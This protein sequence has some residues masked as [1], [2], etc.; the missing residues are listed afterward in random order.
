MDSRKQ[1]G[2]REPVPMIPFFH[3]KS[4][5]TTMPRV[6]MAR[7][8]RYW[9]AQTIRKCSQNVFTQ[10]GSRREVARS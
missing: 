2:I 8:R 6:T 3:L 4:V 9:M 7:S 5:G 1:E 10:S